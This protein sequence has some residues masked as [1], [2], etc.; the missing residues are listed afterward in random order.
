MK[1]TRLG[2][3][4][5]ALG[6]FAVGCEKEENAPV[7]PKQTA[8]E[9]QTKQDE[10]VKPKATTDSESTK[11]TASTFDKEAAVSDIQT[12][13]QKYAQ[14]ISGKN[15]TAYLETLSPQSPNYKDNEALMRMWSQQYDLEAKVES[16]QVTEATEK[17]AKVRAVQILRN[18]NDMEFKDER[19]TILFDMSYEDTWKIKGMTIEKTEYLQEG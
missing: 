5:L 2:F 12:V 16:I 18:Q 13:I 1:W 11:A 4:A 6:I 14:A 17:A 15:V 3:A 7:A 9:Q 19:S 10:S 8:T